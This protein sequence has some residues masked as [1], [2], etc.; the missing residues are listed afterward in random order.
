M[1]NSVIQLCDSNSDVAEI[2]EFGLSLQG[3]SWLK[4]EGLYIHLPSNV[5]PSLHV[6]I[7]DL[8][9]DG[10]L[11]FSLWIPSSGELP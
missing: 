9:D 8:T 2:Q 4:I 10:S 7:G 3:C 11:D 5:A 6:Y 1:L